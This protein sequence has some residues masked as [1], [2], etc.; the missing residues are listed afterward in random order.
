MSDL[1]NHPSHYSQAAV[2]V[3]FEPA[4]LTERLPHPIASAVEYILRAGK[5]EGCPEEVDLKKARWWLKRALARY[6]HED[7]KLDPLAARLLW[8][9]AFEHRNPMLIS[10]AGCVE[11]SRING[12]CIKS[13]LKRL[14]VQLDVIKNDK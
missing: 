14:D 5:K 2:T 7:V 8:H 13:A 6:E 11:K 12:K 3:R 10:L 9:F 4:D 1:I